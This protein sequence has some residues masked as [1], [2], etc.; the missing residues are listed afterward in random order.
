LKIWDSWWFH[1]ETDAENLGWALLVTATAGQAA[2]LVVS[3]LGPVALVV[4]DNLYLWLSQ[5]MQGKS[6]FIVRLV[7]DECGFA[8]LRL[9]IAKYAPDGDTSAHGML[10]VVIQP[11]WWKKSPHSTRSFI[12]VV[13]GWEALVV[14][15][16]SS[17]HERIGDGIR[18]ATI[19]GYAPKNIQAL[20]QS[21]HTKL[22]TPTGW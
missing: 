20:L 15:H 16:D 6:P 22:D 4:S 9:T 8:A 7:D 17:S 11:T 14:K 10:S 18:C 2:P 21:A 1:C 12:A 3:D 19:M 13:L 5:R